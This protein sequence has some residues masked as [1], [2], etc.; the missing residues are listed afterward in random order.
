MWKRIKIIGAKSFV[1]AYMVVGLTLLAL[2]TRGA[3]WVTGLPAA[4]ATAKAENKVVLLNFTGS[5]W[6]GWCIRLRNE[7]FS[8]P[9]FD[10]YANDHL[11]LVEA[12]FPRHKAQPAEL[13]QAN[14]AL[15]RQFH[16][17][18][19]P[20]LVVLNGD[21]EQL[22]TL[23]Y[24]PGGP[25]AFIASLSRFASHKSG[26]STPPVARETKSSDFPP[27]PPPPLFNGAPT[28]PPPKFDQ[29][30]LKSISGSKNN[31]LAMI[32]NQTFGPGE[33]AT[34]QLAGAPVKVKC[35][36]IRENSVVVSINGGE[37]KEV[38]LKG[39]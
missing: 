17:T 15:A 11:V 16:I 26:G 24:Q 37:Q 25:Q 14:A 29:L 21:G 32:N 30:I 18:G 33:S 8:Q 31:R 27:G 5:D 6:C 13:Q 7:V 35:L 23:G 10:T 22:G 20:T 4:Q 9:E 3:N 36:E 2:S 19:Y 28:F 38:R 39:Q 34:L 12:D 1:R